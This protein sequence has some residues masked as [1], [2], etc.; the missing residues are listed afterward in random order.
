MQPEVILT[1]ENVTYISPASSAGVQDVF[2]SEI[3]AVLWED[4]GVREYSVVVRA[5]EGTEVFRLTRSARGDEETIEFPN[6]IRWSGRNQGGNFVEDGSYLLSVSLT[7][8][9][10]R[11]TEIESV[12]IVVDNTPPTASVNG[13]YGVFSPGGDGERNVVPIRQQGG[14]ADIWT[15]QVFDDEGNLVRRWE[16][17]ENLPESIEWDGRN[18]NG[19]L[20]ADGQYSYALTGQDLAGNRVIARQDNIRVS[21]DVL[22]VTITA[23]QRYF[24]PNDDGVKDSVDF[25]PEF[26][27]TGEVGE[28][29]FTVLDSS[30]ETVEE[31]TGQ[32]EPPATLEFSGRSANSALPE[33]DYSARLSILQR[34]GERQENT[35]GTVTLDITAPTAE[36]SSQYQVFSPRSDSERNSV[37][38][39]QQG[40]GADTWTGEIRDSDGS[41]VRRWDVGRTSRGEHRVGWPERQW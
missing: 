8:S 4:T 23:T 33:G 5:E 31:R 25:T 38:I 14:D 13:E 21:T 9:A 41:T 22:S 34:N 28:W 6:E 32:G 3:E 19:D 11:S 10:G 37:P 36:T 15:G 30:G 29:V 35:S 12:R 20:V 27:G 1:A 7:D 24:S 39:S 18:E 26:S 16:W 17:P 2:V 40:S